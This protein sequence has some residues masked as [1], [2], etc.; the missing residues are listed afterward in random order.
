[1]HMGNLLFNMI[2]RECVASEDPISKFNEI[3]DFVIVTR[4]SYVDNDTSRP[5][6][7]D[8]VRSYR[9]TGLGRK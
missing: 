9:D 6:S 2:I 8:V 3:L 7:T 4:E 5:T 1:M